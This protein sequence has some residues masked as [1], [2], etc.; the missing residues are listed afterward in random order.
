MNIIGIIVEYNPFHNGH[1][2]HINKIKELYPDSIIIAVMSG[3]YTQRGDSSILNKWDKVSIALNHNV[4]IVIELPYPFATQSADI[5]AKGS[6]QILKELKIDTIV[7]GSES[8]D[9][10]NLIDI[11]HTELNNSNYNKKIREYL[12][13]GLSYSNALSKSL[14]SLTNNFTNTPNDILGISYIK[15]IILQSANIKPVCIKRTNDYNNKDL[16]EEIS[17]ATS[18]RES[19]NKNI[20]IKKYVPKETYDC[21]KGSLSFIDNYYPYLKYKILSEINNLNIYQTVDEGIE[22][23]IKKYIMESA[24]LD[25]LINKVKTKRYTY[26]K[27]KRMFTHILNNFTKEEALKCKNI[28]YIRVLG[29]NKVGKDYLNKIKKDLTVPLI[30]KYSDI[31][32]EMLD[33]EFRTVCIYAS[34]FS[35]QEKKIILE[36]EYKSKPIII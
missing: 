34:I 26:N 16:T 9:I 24:T 17:S 14:K 32:S 2:H 8:N 7:F 3:N 13:E 18:I 11:A 28:N 15:E 31:K 20:D 22:N 6:I 29:F 30:T 12:D 33:I 36:N 1:L 10:N 35:E 19:I 4:D 27:L 21:L 23:R 5:F 25:E